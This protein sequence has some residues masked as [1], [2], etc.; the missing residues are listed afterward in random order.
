MK[1][2][3]VLVVGINP[4]IDNTGINTLINF[5]SEWGTES[6]ALIYT[7]DSL[8]DTKVCNKFFQ[9]SEKKLIRSIIN[10]KVK[11]GNVVCN[12]H[13]CR[14]MENQLYKRKHTEV[15]SFAREFVWSFG[16]WKSLELKDFLDDFN[17]DVLFFPVYSTVYMNRLQNYIAKYTQKPYVVYSSDD[18]YSY[19]SIEQTPLSYIHRFWIRRHEKKLMQNAKKIMV[20]SPKQKEEY[21]LLF[22]KESVILT[23]G[24]DYTDVHYEHLVPHIPIKMIYTGKMIIGRG[25]TLEMIAAAIKKINADG[26]KI[27]LDIYTTDS[28]TSLQMDVFNSSGCKV[29]G[30]IALD[31][32]K[33]VQ[34]EAD[35]LV[36]VEGL[37]KANSK[38]ARLSF[39]TKITDYLK[40]GKCIFAVGDAEIAP[41]DYFNRY[42]SAIT[43]TSEQEIIKKLTKIVENPSLLNK[44]GEKAFLCGKEH[45]DKVVQN[46]ILI[47]TI[48]EAVGNENINDHTCF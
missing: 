1:K 28:L 37:D 43:A 32:V 36:F 5:F 31:E 45:H 4:W 7:R 11:T 10:R 13:S 40:A 41:I 48:C 15:L 47:R 23:K 16:A 14:N 19:L 21:D 9:I 39:S 18:N 34:R 33:K 2:T 12:N 35:I 17:P 42:D 30:A 3:K 44:Y 38:K 26:I 29:K 6:L 22:N 8:P 20:I 46:Q 27:V 25:K 24:I